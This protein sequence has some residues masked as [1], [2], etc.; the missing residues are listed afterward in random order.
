[1]VGATVAT[2]ATTNSLAHP[3][4]MTGFFYDPRT[5]GVAEWDS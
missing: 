3:V 5:D 1:M 2:V 4:Q